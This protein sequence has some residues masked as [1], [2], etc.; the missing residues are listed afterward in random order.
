[1]VH[2]VGVFL[3]IFNPNTTTVD[4]PNEICYD[5]VLILDIQFSAAQVHFAP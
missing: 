2:F 3:G 4:Y 1:M 5:L